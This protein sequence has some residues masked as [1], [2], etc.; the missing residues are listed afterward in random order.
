MPVQIG[1]KTILTVFWHFW[2][3]EQTRAGPAGAWCFKTETDSDRPFWS[4]C[5]FTLRSLMFS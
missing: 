4:R 2:R 1:I 3:V 5:P